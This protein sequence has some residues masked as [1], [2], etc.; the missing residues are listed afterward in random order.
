[1]LSCIEGARHLPD[2]HSTYFC[3]I[4]GQPPAVEVFAQ[5]FIVKALIAV[6]PHNMAGCSRRNMQVMVRLFAD[7][8]HVEQPLYRV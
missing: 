4:A 8:K 7:Y 1:M 3:T 5:N 2:V 6:H